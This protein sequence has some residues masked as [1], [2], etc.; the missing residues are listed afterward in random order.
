LLSG[1]GVVELTLGFWA[2]GWWQRGGALLLA[3]IGAALLVRG[4]AA[5]ARTLEPLMRLVPVSQPGRRSH[6]AVR[7]TT[8]H[9]PHLR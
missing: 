4:I 8:A 2:A 7:T 1:V 3:V 9:V 6:D 5:I